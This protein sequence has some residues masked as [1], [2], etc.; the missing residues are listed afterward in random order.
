MNS[1]EEKIRKFLEEVNRLADN[2]EMPNEED[3]RNIAKKYGIT[4]SFVGKENLSQES[5]KEDFSTGKED[6]PKEKNPFN[7]HRPITE[8]EISELKIDINTKS[9]EDIWKMFGVKS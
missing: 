5:P 1:D 2:D 9:D 4:P 7:R 3:V 8:Q 6:E